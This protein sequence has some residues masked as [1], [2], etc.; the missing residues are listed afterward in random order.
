MNSARVRT[1]HRRLGISLALF[2]FVQAIVGMSMSIGRLASVDSTPQYNFLYSAHAGWHPLGSIY[3]VFLG[4]A[5]AAQGVLGIL[6]FLNRV[7]ARNKKET[8]FSTPDQTGALKKEVPMHTLSFAADIRPLFRP[9]DIESM[10]PFGIDLSSYEDGKKHAQKIYARLSRKDMP[11]DGP[12][13][14]DSLKKF[15]DWMEGGMEP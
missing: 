14:D 8:A 11:C 10:K 9:Y 5:T 15:K 1:I 7:P 6:I 2:L 13:S 3:R 12:W 4:L